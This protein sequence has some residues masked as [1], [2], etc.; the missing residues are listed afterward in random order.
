[1]Q[2]EFFRRF[3]RMAEEFTRGAVRVRALDAINDPWGLLHGAWHAG[4]RIR[5]KVSQGE[6]Y[7]HFLWSAHP[8]VVLVSAYVLDAWRGLRVSGWTTYDVEL[9][10]RP[11]SPSTYSGLVVNG[12]AGPIDDRLSTPVVLPPRA[13]GGSAKRGLRGLYFDPTT[14]DGSDVFCPR[15]TSWILV[16]ERVRESLLT[17][18]IRNLLLER[19]PDVERLVIAASD[20]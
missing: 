7:H 11:S 4:T 19:L 15:G 9:I 5:F 20:P 13:P 14:W 16:A 3:Y 6:T 12:V 18:G 2:H 17:L 1:M 10:G 8:A